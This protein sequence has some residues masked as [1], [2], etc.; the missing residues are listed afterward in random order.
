MRGAFVIG[1]Y[2]F[3]QAT[4]SLAMTVHLIFKSLDVVVLYVYGEEPM[5][6]HLQLSIDSMNLP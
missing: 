1:M 2:Y 5:M 3:Y 6:E 4:V